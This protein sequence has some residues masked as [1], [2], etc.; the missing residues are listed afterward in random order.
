MKRPTLV[1]LES[2]YSAVPGYSDYRALQGTGTYNVISFERTVNLAGRG[3][4]GYNVGYTCAHK[5]MRLGLVKTL[6]EAK[7]L[8]QTHADKAR[9]K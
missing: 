7:L 1:W 3:A 9:R 8:A 5:R 6:D 2:S 4:A